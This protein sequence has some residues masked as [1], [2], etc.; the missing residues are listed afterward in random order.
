MKYGEIIGL[1]ATDPRPV[2]VRLLTKYDLSQKTKG[3]T[4]SAIRVH[5]KDTELPYATLIADPEPY[6]GYM[7]AED[8]FTLYSPLRTECDWLPHRRI[9]RA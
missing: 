8:D 9:S 4:L 3:R 2:I 1:T 7:K 5:L 6:V